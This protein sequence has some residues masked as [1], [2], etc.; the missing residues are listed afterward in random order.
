MQASAPGSCGELV[1]GLLDGQNFL[2]TCP[3]SWYS[4]VRVSFESSQEQ[5]LSAVFQKTQLAIK[6][7]LAYFGQDREFTFTIDSKLPHGKGMASSSA[8]IAA[9][10]VATARALQQQISP[11]EVE[12]IALSIEPTD[13]IFYKGIVAFGHLSGHPNEYLGQALPL[14]IAIFDTGTAVDT[15]SFNKRPDLQELN[16]VNAPQIQ[17][18]YELVKQGFQTNNPALIGQGAT[19]SALANQSILYKPYLEQM[20]DIALHNGALGVNVAHSGT[21]VGLLFDGLTDMQLTACKRDILA[22]NAQIDFLGTA[23]L[24]NGGV[25]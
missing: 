11:Q 20:L 6:K 7:T 19:L 18:A 25:L 10:C 24:V 3:I 1:Q 14:Q 8:D 13:G 9:A 23:S 22:L 5:C 17:K 16:R 12:K 4:S 15:L 2:I 21:V